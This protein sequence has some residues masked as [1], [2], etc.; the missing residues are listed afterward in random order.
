MVYCLN[1]CFIPVRNR[2]KEIIMYVFVDDNKFEYLKSEKWH[3]SRGYVR[4]TKYGLMHRYLTNPPNDLIV[5]HINNNPYDNR[6]SNL[7]ITT[8][9]E[10]LMNIH[11]SLKKTSSKYKGVYYHKLIKK[12]RAVCGKTIIGNYKHEEHAAWAYDEYCRKNFNLAKLNNVKKPDDF[13]EFEIHKRKEYNEKNVYYTKSGKW[14]VHIKRKYYGLFDKKHDAIFHRDNILNS[15][16]SKHIKIIRNND[17]IAIRKII[18]NN[19]EH[20]ILLDDDIYIKLY[21]I[22]LHLNNDGYPLLSNKQILSRYVTNAKIGEII[23]HINGNKLDNRSC[24]LRKV[25]NKENRYNS[26]KQ[27]GTS[28]K[29][30]GVYYNKLR[31]KWYTTIRVN[32]KLL[33]L[34]CYHDED[35][36]GKVRDEAT[37]KY[38][39]IYGK[40]NF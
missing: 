3:L 29:Y 35:T 20:V 40:L 37:K 12:Y 32:N 4:S 6:L 8:Q 15:L 31:K 26:S 24:N 36:A 21:K 18:K 34:G 25:T 39:G 23:D 5:D 28:S 10:N 14:S 1:G 17:S 22:S 38:F 16:V 9:K 7:R 2:K 30:I 13:I 33:Y 19:K 11:K 27:K